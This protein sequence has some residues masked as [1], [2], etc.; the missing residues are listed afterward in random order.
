[1]TDPLDYWQRREK[2]SDRVYGLSGP[3]GVN[4]PQRGPKRQVPPRATVTPRAM[5][6]QGGHDAMNQ[7]ARDESAEA[8]RR[9]AEQQ[10]AEQG[11]VAQDGAEH[12]AERAQGDGGNANDLEAD[13][14][15]ER[16]TLETVDP[17]N[18]PA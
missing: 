2:K 10:Q 8:K 15:I 18:P 9:A 17:D 16:D 7:Q 4:D 13:I 6:Q 5:R 1:M 3:N 11:G 12:R 14:A